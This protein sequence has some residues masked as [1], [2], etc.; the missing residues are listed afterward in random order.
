MYSEERGKLKQT[1]MF[2]IHK[3]LFELF[4]YGTHYSLDGSKK[5]LVIFMKEIKATTCNKKLDLCSHKRVIVLEIHEVYK[6]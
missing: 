2:M 4:T 6:F 5:L 1:I 3:V